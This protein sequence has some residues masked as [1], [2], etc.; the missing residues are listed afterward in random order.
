[1]AGIGVIAKGD[2]FLKTTGDSVYFVYAAGVATTGK[3]G[4]EEGLYDLLGQAGANQPRPQREHIGVI[5]FAAVIGGSLVVTHGR[6]YPW[7]FVGDHTATNAGAI[8]D[9]GPPGFAVGD[10][11]RGR[12]RH[13]RVIYGLGVMGSTIKNGIPLFLD[14]TLQLL[15]QGVSPM[16]GG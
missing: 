6:P 13:I 4:A 9:D 12:V 3:V 1:M 5:V 2:L 15:F 7:Y 10:M 11:L 14:K 8:Y 16:I